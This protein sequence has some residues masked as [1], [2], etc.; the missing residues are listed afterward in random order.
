MKIVIKQTNELKGTN[1]LFVDKIVEE[2][3]VYLMD[4]NGRPLSCEIAYGKAAKND[5]VNGMLLEH[6]IPTN[7]ENNKNVFNVKDII[8]E[9]SYDEYMELAKI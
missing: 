3:M 1:P 2:F 5:I 6:F 8:E 4:D 9:V 7:W